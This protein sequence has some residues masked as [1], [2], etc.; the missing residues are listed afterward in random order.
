MT[1]QL[2]LFTGRLEGIVEDDGQ[3][4]IQERFERFHEANPQV[5]RELR[6]MAL[7]L[8]CKGLPR[9]GIGMLWEVLRY[10]SIQTTGKDFKLNDHFR[11]RY[12]RLLLQREPSLESRI[13][14]RQ[15]RS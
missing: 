4:S 6:R 9:I 8:A 3:G 12:A 14:L 5:Y 10:S 1:Q 2:D 11:S 13:E 7:D 15:L